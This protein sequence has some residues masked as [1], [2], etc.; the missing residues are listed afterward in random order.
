MS[1]KAILITGANGEI[2]HGLVSSLMERNSS[3]RIV[4]V[5]VHPLSKTLTEQCHEVIV[6]DIMDSSLHDRLAADGIE[7]VVTPP[8]TV[9]QE[10]NSRVKCDKIDA[11]RLAINLENGDFKTCYV[12]DKELREDRQA[13]RMLIQVQKDIVRQKNRIRKFLDF[14][15]YEEEFPAGAWYDR[16]YRRLEELSISEPLQYCL[17]LSLNMLRHLEEIKKK[18]VCRL[19]VLILLY[20]YQI[21][22]SL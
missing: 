10:K 4:A 13:S 5:D 20:I 15:G 2:G 14:H 19:L 7:C 1:T 12:P 9:T 21:E 22:M 11:R 16:D 3:T 6:G 8:H 17:T 18:L